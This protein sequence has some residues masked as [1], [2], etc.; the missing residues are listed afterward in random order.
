MQVKLKLSEPSDQWHPDQASLLEKTSQDL[1][2]LDPHAREDVIKFQQK[3]E[4]LDRDLDRQ[5]KLLQVYNLDYYAAREEYRTIT[6]KTKAIRS[7]YN[8]LNE[9]LKPQ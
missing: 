4:K 5:A 8:C 3:L 1:Q 9:Q 2:R 6:D 7:T